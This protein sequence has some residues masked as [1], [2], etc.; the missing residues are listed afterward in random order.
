VS[1]YDS[2]M[3]DSNASKALFMPQGKRMCFSVKSDDSIETFTSV[4]LNAF[5]ARYVLARVPR[6]L[7]RDLFVKP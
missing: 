4:F 7:Y 5:L 1:D 2:L 3:I 6:W